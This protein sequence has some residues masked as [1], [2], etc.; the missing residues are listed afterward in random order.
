M[1]TP[2]WQHGP[3]AAADQATLRR[4]NL[5]LVLRALRDSGPRSRARLASDLRL[6]KATVSSLVTE[7]TERGPGARRR[8][9]ARLGRSAGDRGRAGRTPGLRHRRRDQRAPRGH[10]GPGPP[11]RRAQRA[12]AVPRRGGRVAGAGHRPARRASSRRPWRTSSA[13][14][15][16]PVGIVVG[17]AGLID[18]ETGTLSLAPNLGWRDVP[19]A[20]LLRERL[21]NP[22]TPSASTTRPTSPP[23]PRPCRETRCAATSWSSTARSGSA[24]ASSPTAGSCAGSRGTP[25]SSA[26]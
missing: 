6:N 10:A 22:P 9:G 17:I 26:T 16:V 21:G 1:S 24:A 14:G 18:R 5:S 20:A 2:S 25:A 4:S 13:Q 23:L 19:V 15:G 11:G 8:R 7:L 12:T 3:S